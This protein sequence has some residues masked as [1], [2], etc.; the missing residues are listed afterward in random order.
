MFVQAS[1]GETLSY[2]KNNEP[3]CTRAFKYS[4]NIVRGGHC[5]ILNGHHITQYNSWLLDVTSNMDLYNKQL[6]N[7][8]GRRYRGELGDM[9]GLLSGEETVNA[10]RRNTTCY[11]HRRSVGDSECTEANTVK[12]R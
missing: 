8:V 12:H 7:R 1:P 5:S 6:S 3:R 9:N 10:H 4:G 11:E 2:S